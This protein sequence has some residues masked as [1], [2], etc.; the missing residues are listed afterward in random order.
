MANANDIKNGAVVKEGNDLW[1][2]IEFQHVKPGKGPA[3]IRTKRKNVMT[4][5]VVEKT[6]NPNENLEFTNIDR[7]NMQYTYNDGANYVFMDTKTFEQAE[8]SETV[9]GDDRKYLTEGETEVTVAF[10]E[11]NA[12]FMELPL[13]ANVTIKYTEPDNQGNSANARLKPATF[14][15]SAGEEFEVQVPGFIEIGDRIVVDTRTNEFK[16]RLKKA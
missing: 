13:S 3:F 5:K 14:E 11:G 15:N 8:I 1:M 2:F 16:E 6:Y 12:L 10:H 7:K 4:G 9:V